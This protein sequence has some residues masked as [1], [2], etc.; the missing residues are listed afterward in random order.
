MPQDFTPNILSLPLSTD[1]QRSNKY[2]ARQSL[3]FKFS[4]ADGPGQGS[5]RGSHVYEVNTWLWNFGQPQPRVAGLSVAKTEKIRKRCRVDAAKSAWETRRAQKRAAKANADIW[6]TYTC[7][8]PVIYHWSVKVALC[9]LEHAI[10][11]GREESKLFQC[12]FNSSK[13]LN[14]KCKYEWDI[15]V[16][17][18]HMSGIFH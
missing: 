9:A 4:C 13:A 3:D 5:R 6:Y 17:T 12:F 14:L 15:S 1:T 11:L 18:K 16:K 7:H 10:C 8:I 2:S